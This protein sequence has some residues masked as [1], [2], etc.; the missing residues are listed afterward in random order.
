MEGLYTLLAMEVEGD[1]G[2]EGEEEGGGNQRTLGALVFLTQEAEPNGTTIVDVCNGFNE[3]SRFAM[4][5]AV[6]NHWLA[7]ARFVF[8]CYRHWAQLLLHQPGELPVTILSREGFTQGDLLSMVL[9]GIT[10]A[11]LAEELRAADQEL[12]SPFYAD[13]ASFDGSARQIAQLLKL[14][15]KSGRT[16]DT[17]P[18]RLSPSLSQTLQSKR[19]QRSGNLTRRGFV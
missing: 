12:L 1:R 15:I 6:R 2:S 3:M 11:P 7:G 10:L 9:Y 14:L 16:G 13:N 5:W 17:S 4:L 8:N 19:R 18:S